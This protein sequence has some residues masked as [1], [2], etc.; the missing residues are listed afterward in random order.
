MQVPSVAGVL[1]GSTL[2]LIGGSLLF[3]VIGTPAGIPL[4]IAGLG[5]MFTPKR[6]RP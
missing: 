2:F 1:I 5:L 6:S 3:T 4:F